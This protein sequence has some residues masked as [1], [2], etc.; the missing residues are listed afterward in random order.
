MWPGHRHFVVPSLT[1]PSVQTAT[2]AE[3]RQLLDMPE[4]PDAMV[5]Q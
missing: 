1:L 3:V 2:V 5:V 4:L